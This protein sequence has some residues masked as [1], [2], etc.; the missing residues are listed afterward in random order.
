MNL[1]AQLKKKYLIKDTT[2]LN[3]CECKAWP[4]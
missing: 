4:K 3:K 2:K 1:K